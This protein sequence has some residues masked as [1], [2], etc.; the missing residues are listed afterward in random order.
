MFYFAADHTNH[1]ISDE[2][3]TDFENFAKEEGTLDGDEQQGQTDLEKEMTNVVVAESL[4]S[5]V[6]ANQRMGY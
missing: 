1:A 6:S 5:R 4:D 2:G 3:E